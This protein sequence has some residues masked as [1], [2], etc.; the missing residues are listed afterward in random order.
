MI[1]LIIKTAQI[2]I[3]IFI[4]LTTISCGNI[5][6]SGTSGNGNVI[7]ETRTIPEEFKGVKVANGIDVVLEQK[8][9][10]SVEVTTDENLQ[11]LIM[12]EV[13]DGILKIYLDE[14][15]IDNEELLVYVS[16]PVFSSIK[17]S[18]GAE[19]SNKGTIT[20]ENITL[21][22]SSGSDI[23]VKILAKNT[24]CKSSSGS[25]I[26]ATGKVLY[27]TTDS[28]SGSTIDAEE[29]IAKNAYAEASS[30]SETII[31]V[32]ESLEAE[33]SSGSTIK[34]VSSPKKKTIQESSGGSVFTE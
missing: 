19:V 15:V 16:N 17:T 25:D 27:L 3:T 4:L 13:E 20:E 31:N 23:E 21:N 9:T 30:G 5:Q 14:T 18:S 28:S 26:E 22:A 33:A 32:V 12:T 8:N 24:S 7:T 2:I 11:Q 29:F 6:I 10:P 34:C 1:K